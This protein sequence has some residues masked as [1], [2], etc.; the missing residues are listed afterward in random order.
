MTKKV[1]GYA[2]VVVSVLMFLIGL[3]G[4]LKVIKAFVALFQGPTGYELGYASGIILFWA[5][6]Y[7][8]SIA[9]LRVGRRW[10]KPRTKLPVNSGPLDQG[11]PS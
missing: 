11:L 6:F 5:A 10:T 9:L 4:V 8:A 2:F 7:W 1:P 3:T